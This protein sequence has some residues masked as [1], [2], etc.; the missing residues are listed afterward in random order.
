MAQQNA[1]S[2]VSA[3]ACSLIGLVIVVSVVGYFSIPQ[4]ATEKTEL[5]AKLDL[6]L[7]NQ[8]AAYHELFGSTPIV[9][10]NYSFS[11]PI[12]IYRAVIVGLESDGW[13]AASLKNMSVYV[14][15]QCHCALSNCS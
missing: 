2:V 13:T 4:V 3:I 1:K 15:H 10:G 9:G 8:K 6:A 12:P 14:L 11:P 7:N 5:L